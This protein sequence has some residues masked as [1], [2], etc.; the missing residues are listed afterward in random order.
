MS[1]LGLTVTQTSTNVATPVGVGNKAAKNVL[2]FR[3]TDGANEAG[4]YADTT[5]YVP[6]NNPLRPF[7]ATTVEEIEYAGKWQPLTY[8][9]DT[10]QPATPSYIAPHWGNVIPFALTSSD[11]FR[12][13]PPQPLTSQGFLDQAKHILDTQA[14]LTPKQ[15]VMA[16]Y[17][18]DGPKS[19]LPPRTLDNFRILRCPKGP[20]K[21]R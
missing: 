3:Q 4:N 1:K 6:A 19:E 8:L 9:N 2:V 7:F 20:F 16:E 12:P 18:A 13:L 17:W 10:I 14:N 15:K 11:Q 21:H 5:G